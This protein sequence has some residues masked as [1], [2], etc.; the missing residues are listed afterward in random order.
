M[1]RLFSI[2]STLL[3]SSSSPLAGSENTDF[4]QITH[5]LPAPSEV[6]LATG[7]PGPDYWQ[8]EANYQIKVELDE[9][10]SRIQGSETVEY[11]NHS[12]HLLHYLW[13]QLD[14]NALAQGSKRQRST[15]APDLAPRDGKP[16]EVE[17]DIFRSLIYR[18]KF[19]GGY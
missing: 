4:E 15:Q 7:A 2:L 3:V 13:V 12:P 19:A 9:A 5:L 1:K 17:Y 11:T 16:V 18:Q 14:Q 6:R 10:E 8:Q